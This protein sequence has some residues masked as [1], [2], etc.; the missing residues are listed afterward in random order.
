MRRGVYKFSDEKLDPTCPCPTC[1][2][3]SRAYLHHLTKTKETLG[4]QLL[5]QHNI[6]F[7]HSLM[8]EIRESILQ[9]R[10]LALYEA[11]RIF[12]HEDDIDNPV[13]KQKTKRKKTPALTLGD[14]A[15]HI[16]MEGFASIKHVSSG[17]IMH[18]RTPPMED[19]RALY[20]EQSN[21]AERLRTDAE[22]QEPLIV[23]DV[24]LGAA[25]NAMAAIECYEEQ[26]KAGPVRPMRI[27]SFENDLDSLELAVRHSD[28]FLY[29]RHSGP[30]WILRQGEWQSR[31]FPGLSW[32]LVRGSFLDTMESV[33]ERPE[34][35]FYDM[36][37]SKTCGDQWTLA[38]FERLARV[39]SEKGAELFTYTC[40]TASRVAML[41]A[42]FH[43]ARGRNAG[44]KV[45]TT[46]AFTPAARTR[47]FAGRHELLAA[48]WFAK[49]KR[50]SAKVPAELSD[51][52]QLA[53]ETTILNHE[54]FRGLAAR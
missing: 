27:V 11:K 48:E 28:K 44:E 20:I 51:A 54:Q 40:S 17:E 25:A 18:S 12:L 1:K 49:W 16:A 33:E 50:S 31:E 53:L 14:Y 45:E 3:Y 35:I 2:R 30:T 22:A 7:Y 43:V 41:G 47:G 19:A 6:Y 38:L 10:F 52:E 36:F 13:H 29:L 8:R 46:I 32:R 21:L 23:W 15:V 4:W 39:C 37:S 34:V 5:G 9:D 26:A 24:G 42:G